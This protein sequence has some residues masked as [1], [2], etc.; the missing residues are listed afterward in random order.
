MNDNS[1]NKNWKGINYETSKVP[2]EEVN[3]G[4]TLDLKMQFSW[5]KRILKASK[6]WLIIL[7]V[8]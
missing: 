4:F 5:N 2:I 3:Y 6:F 7:E 1:D 8:T